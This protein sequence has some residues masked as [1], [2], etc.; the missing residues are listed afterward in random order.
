MANVLSVFVSSSCYELRDLRASVRDFLKDLG[1][2]PQLSEDPAFPRTSG[3]QPYVTCLRTLAECPL[4]I[5]LLERRCG[6]PLADWGP[7][8]EYGGLRP[9]H[10]EL[11]HALKMNKKLLLYVHE[12]TL[13][14]YRQWQADPKGYVTLVGDQ[15]PELATLEL[16]HELRTHHPAPY[17]EKFSDGSDV[18]SSLKL[19]LFNEI[20][21]SLKDQEAIN[22]DHA[23][24]LMEK[25]L[26]A[27]P[28]IRTKIQAEL[29]PDLAKNLDLLTVERKALEERLAGAQKESQVSLDALRRERE[30]LDA[31]IASLQ[32]EGK[33]AQ[34]VLTMAAVRDARW[35][36]L[37]RSTYMPKQPGRVPFHNSL[38]VE[39]RGYHTAG[40]Q[41]KPIL[42]EVTWLKLSHTENNLHRG[43]T[44]GIIFK[45]SDFVPGV[46]FAYR[47]VGDSAPP[48]GNKDYFWR[49]PNIYFGE[50]LEVSTHDDEIEGPLSWRDCEFQVKNPEGQ[51]SNWITF[52]YP[53]DDAKLS[54]VMN[55]SA[56]E[57][58]RRVAKGDNAGAVEP[59][60]KAMVIADRMLGVN[61]PETSALRTE[62]NAALDNRTLDKLRFQV[63]TRVRVI[64]GEHTGKS[65]VIDTLA[66]RHVKPYWIK[67]AE[68]DVVAASDE[69]VEALGS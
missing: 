14:A 54:E 45:G 12:L 52:T 32:A 21:A 41:K 50:Y 29:N 10:A 22:R 11:R 55:Q 38:E 26:S 69:E 20:Y 4:V 39:L 1:I 65:G 61:A 44:A 64:A 18:L 16:L 58:R 15:G 2:N 3:D 46:T 33:N 56:A 5:G 63:G 34:M 27:A 8:P 62:W 24:Y 57:G 25:I 6:Q 28:E 13:S 30:G 42:R 66:L 51:L 68:G 19:N 48:P 49:L 67:A 23:E 31:Q 53:F 60:R 59:L 17:Y 9:T 35:L 40:G 7:F 36:T 43:Y 37:V 47:R